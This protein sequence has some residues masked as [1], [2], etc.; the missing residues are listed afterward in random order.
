MRSLLHLPL[1]PGS[2]FIRLMLAEK[3]LAARLVATPPWSA[4]NELA[5]FNP[6][7]TI[8]V[9]IDEPPTGG[10]LPISPGLA[11]AEYLEEVYRDPPLYPSTS[12]GRAE[13]R[14]VAHWF[15]TKFENEVNALIVRR[16]IEHRPQGR[17]WGDP[18]PVRAAADALA[19]HLDYVTFLLERR[20]F[21]A[22][23]KLTIADLAAAAHFS[24]NDYFGLIPWS[25]FAEARAWYQKIKSRPSMRP[26]LA[27]RLEG[28][29]AAAHYADL[30]F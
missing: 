8:P 28:A 2:R 6:A 25:D 26:L 14:R 16:R 4:E 29:A 19:W 7:L 9:L 3:G 12:A 1:D 18:E 20:A 15:E 13:A 30:D 23:D 17:K 10:E 5:P 27:D 11:I 21:L 22:G 24:V